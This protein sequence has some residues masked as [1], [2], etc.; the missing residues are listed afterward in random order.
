VPDDRLIVLTMHIPLYTTAS[1]IAS[2]N[3]VDRDELFGLLKN[4]EH[5]LALAG[6]MHNL[7]HNFIGGNLGWQGEKPLHQLI[8]AAVC[9]TWWTGINDERGI[10]GADQRDGTPNG[11]HIIRFEGNQYRETFKAAKFGTDFQLRIS[12]PVGKIARDKIEQ[13]MVVVNVF[14]GSEKSIVKCQI[15]ELGFQTMQQTLMKDPFYERIYDQIKDHV[16][17]W[18]SPDNSTHIWTIPLPIDL[19]S[20]IHKI[21]VKTIDQ[22]G[23]QY[24]AA[25]IFEVD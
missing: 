1:E 24:Q 19:K 10:P 18:I 20:G 14:D 11:Y 9:G 8:C 15:D 13:T 22:F 4:R 17:S 23:N 6:H 2:V 12:S 21:I 25:E 16:P 7:E 5:V 3:V